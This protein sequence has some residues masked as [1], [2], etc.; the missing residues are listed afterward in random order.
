VW[1]LPRAPQTDELADDGG[2]L[3]TLRAGVGEA[4]GRPVLRGILAAYMAVI[5]VIGVDEY[6]PNLWSESGTHTDV[7]TAW[8]AVMVAAEAL[9]TLASHRLAHTRRRSAGVLVPTVGALLVSVGAWA[10]S[11]VV[12][13]A[14]VVGYGL[15]ATW[16]VALEIRLQDAISGRARATVTSVAGLSNEVASITS[17]A[18]FG[19]FA[20]AT[21]W[22]DAVWVVAAAFAVPVALTA[23]R[24]RPSAE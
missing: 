12:L 19:G 11:V 10:G 21:S 23:A 6:V 18:A 2:Y 22:R 5:L 3:D 8:L 13:L 15:L 17:F 16:F 14:V 24:V 9:G 1:L 7:L 20:S 4:V